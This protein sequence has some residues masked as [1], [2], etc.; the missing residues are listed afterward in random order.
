MLLLLSM[1]ALAGPY[2]GR[3]LFV[4]PDTNPRREAEAFRA[5]DAEAAAVMDLLAEQPVALWLA[6]QSDPRWM[7]DD[8]LDRAGD[9]LRTFVVYNLPQRDC[10]AWSMGG[11]QS[12]DDYRAYVS[13]VAAG[14]E[15]REAIVVLEPDALAHDSCLDDGGRAERYQLMAEAVRT[16]SEGGANVYID[17][18]DSN[19][20]PSADMA[21]RLRAAGVDDA[22][23]IALNVSHTELTEN[24]IGYAEE[25]R[26][27][28]GIDA[29]YVIDTSR[30]GIGP[31]PDNEW[32]N[33][34][35]RAIGQLP[36][37]EVP[38]GALDA[39][40]WIKPPGESD[41]LCNG[42]PAAG[43]WWPEY[44]L[45]LGRTARGR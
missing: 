42:G 20:I 19:W 29:H 28:L 21:P 22:A 45:E 25:L 4:E 15:G 12:A 2:A 32:C 41:G 17:A 37:T 13:E 9:Q 1:T 40:L 10:G 34:R 23:G 6:G 24:E 31:S 43:V 5:W 33:P 35:H 16:L 38:S 44:A 14:L 30:N 36:T 8:S 3:A 26:S 7:V 11:A 18:G 27:L 39:L